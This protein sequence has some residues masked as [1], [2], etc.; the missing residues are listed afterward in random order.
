[1]EFL[2]KQLKRFLKGTGM[3]AVVFLAAIPL[4]YTRLIWR[5]RNLLRKGVPSGPVSGSAPTGER[6][7]EAICAALADIPFRPVKP[8]ALGLARGALENSFVGL[9]G[10]SKRTA[11]LLYPY[12]EEFECGAIESLD[13]TPLEVAVGL[14]RDGLP[15]PGLVVSHGYM[16]TKNDHYIISLALEAFAGWGFNVLAIDLRDFGRSMSLGFNPTT[17]GMRE[18]EDLLAA[19]KYLGGQR[20]VTT[21]GVTGFSMGAMSTMRAAYLNSEYHYITGG[22]IAWNGVSDGRRE[23][24]HLDGKPPP[25]DPYF[26]FYLGFRLMHF[27]RRLDM[28]HSAT[29]TG[30][31][32]LLAE[33][34]SHYDFFTYLSRISAPH[35]GITFDELMDGITGKDYLD[36]VETPLLVMHSLDDPICP[37]SEMEPLLELS[38]DNPNLKVMVMPTGMHCVFPYLDRE[39]FFSLTRSFFEYWADWE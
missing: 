30:A 14:H 36:G 38:K 26:P 2:K 17:L 27:L 28:K 15:R 18:G 4:T 5:F 1:M 19:A 9:M 11:G 23:L 16:G 12:P 25:T 35:Y 13:G 7:M 32:G 8:L 3:V 29:D 33:P 22:A 39:W 21:V 10:V 34:F 6:D 31:R 37:V 20:G 24:A